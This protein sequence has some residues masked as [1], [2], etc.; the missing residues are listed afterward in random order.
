MSLNKE[1]ILLLITVAVCALLF[2]VGGE[3]VD[4]TMPRP[5]RPRE[6]ES[7]PLP[8]VVIERPRPEGEVQRRDIFLRP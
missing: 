5:G 4:T 8:P 6:V 2:A 3:E 1:K 7:L